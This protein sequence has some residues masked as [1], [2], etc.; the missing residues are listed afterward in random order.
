MTNPKTYD[1]ALMRDELVRDEAL[2]L[3]T[4]RCTAGKL[5]IGVGRNLDD[6]GISA[7]ETA[8]LGITAASCAKDGLTRAQ[9]MALLD[10]DLDRVERDLDRR[11][12]WWRGLDPVR[13][14]VMVNM[15]FNLGITRLM[16]F[17][18][19]LRM[20]EASRFEDAARNMLLS[21]WAKQVGLRALRLSFMM[22]TGT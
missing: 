22:K 2:K 10:S 17:R 7:A 21:L 15:A 6:V 13:Q 19:T 16:G 4:Y 5:T 18:N 14:R 8:A 3:R 12:P 9:A 11:T 1:R 20:I